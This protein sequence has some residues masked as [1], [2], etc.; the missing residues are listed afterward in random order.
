[1]SEDRPQGDRTSVIPA[2]AATAN[3]ASTRPPPVELDDILL[4]E[5]GAPPPPVPT[6][7]KEAKAD[8]VKPAPS[9]DPTMVGESA[10]KD[11]TRDSSKERAT[12]PGDRKG[13]RPKMTLRIPDD[14]VARPNL[15][16]MTP[17]SEPNVRVAADIKAQLAARASS[18]P[19]QVDDRTSAIPSTEPADRASSPPP[20]PAARPLAVE[21]PSI[22]DADTTAQMPALRSGLLPDLPEDSWTPHMPMAVDKTTDPHLDAQEPPPATMEERSPPSED[23]PVE[24]EEPVAELPAVTLQDG[25][26][27]IE[28]E[29]PTTPLLPVGERSDLHDLPPRSLELGPEDIVAVDSAPRVPANQPPAPPRKAP[30]VPPPAPPV[31]TSQPPVASGPPPM[32]PKA[33]SVPPE[34]PIKPVKPPPPAP[35]PPAPPV[36]ERASAAP[37]LPVAPAGDRASGAP[38]LPTPAA[39]AA[40]PAAASVDRISA[41]PA[42]STP[43]AAPA[44][45][46]R[47]STVPAVPS[48]PAAAPPARARVPSA[49]MLIVTPSVAGALAPPPMN[50]AAAQ[51]K[52]TRPWWEE[53]FNDDFLR[54]SEKLTERQ[55]GR[56][57][58][59]IE[60]SL[61]VMKGAML[62]DLACGTGRHAVE[63]TLR[64][65]QVVGFDL[66]LSMLARAA[67]EAEER[68]ASLN[69]VQG[70]M[71]EMTFEETFD[72]IYCWNTS[73]GYFEEEKNAQVI[74][75]VHR[76]LKKGGQFLLDVANRDFVAQQSPSLVWFEGDGCICMDEMQVDW[77]TS[78]LRVKRTMMMDDGRS[79]EIEYSIRIYALHELGRLLHDHGFR[80]AEVSGRTATPGVFF[81]SA[82]P[83]TLILAEK[84]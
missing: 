57:V 10:A 45:A 64:G 77:I 69:F 43:A 71:R 54:A 14:Q 8:G 34:A 1:M 3:R 20:A 53:L 42:A 78:R 4:E 5:E 83:R 74:S 49:P 66:S 26:P 9:S 59:F 44:P 11:G 17:P 33:Q 21:E 79:K 40:P 25:A 63:L 15:P 73:F 39:V 55:I 18:A 22:D 50:E 67:E 62:L 52:R 23:I 51:R 29:P 76:A 2:P 82:S 70:D 6:K 28:P 46:D 61:G 81:G 32:R 65:Y 31:A 47:A 30:S 60:D 35:T 37:P 12:A 68:A 80:V 84:R 24:A 56:E 36:A 41:A 16:P 72:G 7:P 75:R 13:G 38:P 58:D 19:L 48:A 27:A